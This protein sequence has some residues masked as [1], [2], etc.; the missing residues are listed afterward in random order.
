MR[1]NKC[2]AEV[3][4]RAQICLHC[5]FPDPAAG[6]P[7]P[8]HRRIAR[9]I[10]DATPGSRTVRRW[11]GRESIYAVRAR[12]A[13]KYLHGAGIEFGALNARLDVPKNVKV[14]Y[15]DVAGS[16]GLAAA[17]ARMYG[18][19]TPPS[20]V[21]DIQTMADIDDSSIDFVVANQVIEHVEN[22]L[23]ALRTIN[24]VLRP[25]GIAFI[26]LPDRR[27]TFDRQR[28]TTPLSHLIKDDQEG[29]EGGRE[30]HYD[31][32]VHHAEGLEGQERK[33]RVAMMLANNVN[34]HFHVW[35]YDT[36]KQMFTYAASD[37]GLAIVHSQLN[38]NEGIWI[39][40]K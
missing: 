4:P 7:D 30:D 26:T 10:F 20:I 34:I 16:E 37:I 6:K 13:R 3:S 31:D 22:P 28:S 21:A 35:D 12:L 14:T 15:A 17:A 18:G 1:C 39:L 40:R 38:G 32:W 24:R 36:M 2:G 8:D 23:R 19:V 9:A 11:L 29:P 33:E 27:F 25:N 5:G